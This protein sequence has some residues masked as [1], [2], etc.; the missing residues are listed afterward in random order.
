MEQTQILFPDTS[1]SWAALAWLFGLSALPCCLLKTLG[2]VGFIALLGAATS[3]IIMLV[4]SCLSLL[5]L[6][7]SLS[8]RR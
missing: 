5:S 8:G 2:H 1:L 7:L 6:S 3:A 4:F